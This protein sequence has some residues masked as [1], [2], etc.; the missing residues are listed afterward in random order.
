LSWYCTE[1][2]WKKKKEEKEKKKKRRRERET[3]DHRK[4]FIKVHET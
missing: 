1:S 3:D 4:I 2:L